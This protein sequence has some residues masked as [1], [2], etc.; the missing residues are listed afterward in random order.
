MSVQGVELSGTDGKTWYTLKEC[1][2]SSLFIGAHI[3][4]SQAKCSP[5]YSMCCMTALAGT[6]KP[7]VLQAV[8]AAP[9]SL[10]S[11]DAPHTWDPR[12]W[13]HHHDSQNPSWCCS[14]AGDQPHCLLPLLWGL[15]LT[16]CVHLMVLWRM[17]WGAGL[18][19]PRRPSPF[20]WDSSSISKAQRKKPWCAH[21]P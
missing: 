6:S 18:L 12:S 3:C 19:P 10:Q 8:P 15:G 16:W 11:L 9:A 13:S 1:Q 21:W 20:P 14:W 2:T 7:P 4:W 17:S 5:G